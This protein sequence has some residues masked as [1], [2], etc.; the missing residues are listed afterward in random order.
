MIGTRKNIANDRPIIGPYHV[1]KEGSSDM[2]FK[3][4]NMLHTLR[5]WVNDDT[6]WRAILR[7]MHL[8]FYHTTVS[9]KEIETFLSEATGFNL[10]AFFNQYLRPTKLPTLEYKITNKQLIYRWYNTV[11][12]FK[13]PVDVFIDGIPTRLL[14]TSSWQTINV[15]Q[16]TLKIDPDYYIL[17]KR[18]G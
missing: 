7:E 2:Y 1:N 8:K 10:S 4:A 3:G 15:T 9:S 14:P 17:S 18:M 13:M 11:E 6:K 16:V 12:D 5:Q